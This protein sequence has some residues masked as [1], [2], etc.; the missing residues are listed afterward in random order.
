MVG[1]KDLPCIFLL[2]YE[3]VTSDGCSIAL[4]LIIRFC[5]HFEPQSW[6]ATLE[7]NSKTLGTCFFLGGKV[8]P[9]V[10]GWN[11][12][13]TSEVE[14]VFLSH[15]FRWFYTCEV[16]SGQDF[17]PPS[18]RRV[19]LRRCFWFCQLRLKD[20]FHLNCLANGEG[21]SEQRS[22]AMYTHNILVCIWIC[23]HTE[24][25]TITEITV[26]LDVVYCL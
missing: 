1:F 16:Q 26:R 19:S 18:T 13:S 20:S 22:T 10:N 4:F 21:I 23:I 12:A 2:G 9:R 24:I 25:R 11:R 17:S 7:Q 5:C 3:I 15:C 6:W 14:I 8:G